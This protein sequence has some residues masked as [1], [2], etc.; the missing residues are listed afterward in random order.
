MLID[1]LLHKAEK[2]SVCLFVCL[3][4][5]TYWHADNSAVTASIEMGL[6]EIKSCVF[7]D[8]RVY[9]QKST[10]LTVYEHKCTKDTSIS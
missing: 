7:K 10:E 1:Y 5:C 8:H 4:A 6:A 3:S 2:P 9:L